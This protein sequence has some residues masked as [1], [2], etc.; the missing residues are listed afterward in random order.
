MKKKFIFLAINFIFSLWLYGQSQDSIAHTL[1]VAD[2]D[3]TCHTLNA[4][5]KKVE[6]KYGL[7]TQIA[8]HLAR[9]MG[10]KQ[11]KA[12]TTEANSCCMYPPLGK[13][14]HKDK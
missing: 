4:Q 7:T 14:T 12:K 2:Y 5:G 10:Y 6:V 11:H 9:T 3:Y 13:T 1:L 8:Q